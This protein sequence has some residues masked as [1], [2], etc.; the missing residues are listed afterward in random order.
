MENYRHV[1]DSQTASGFVRVYSASRLMPIVTVHSKITDERASIPLDD[2][3]RTIEMLCE[4]AEK[5]WPSFT[6]KCMS[7]ILE[8]A[9]KAEG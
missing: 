5:S 1:Y 8:R 6:R 2:L 3:Q 4:A 9:A 7:T